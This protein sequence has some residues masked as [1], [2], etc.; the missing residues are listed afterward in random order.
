MIKCEECK[1][2]KDGACTLYNGSQIIKNQWSGCWFG[3][4][5]KEGEE[6]SSNDTR[7]L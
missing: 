5:K 3:T 2:L 4:P 1:Y 7:Y 6:V